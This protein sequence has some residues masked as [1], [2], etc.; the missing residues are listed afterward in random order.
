M[1]LDEQTTVNPSFTLNELEETKQILCGSDQK[2][3]QNSLKR[4]KHKLVI[5]DLKKEAGKDW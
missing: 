4:E 2:M 5:Y 1:H 3:K